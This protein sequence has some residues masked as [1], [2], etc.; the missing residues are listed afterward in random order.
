MVGRLY[1]GHEQ[2][3]PADIDDGDA[4]PRTA[5]RVAMREHVDEAS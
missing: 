2:G 4:L 3:V 5:L 1:V